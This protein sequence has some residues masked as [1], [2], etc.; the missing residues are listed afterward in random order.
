MG[1]VGRL[2]AQAVK[3]SFERAARQAPSDLAPALAAIRGVQQF[4]ADETDEIAGI[5]VLEENSLEI[6]FEEALAVY[7][8]MLADTRTAITCQPDESDDKTIGSGPFRLVS[9]DE[10]RVV[11]ERVETTGVGSGRRWTPSSSGP[12]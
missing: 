5:E 8:A 12:G 3:E 11:L 7:P 6:G 10:R 2:T 1:A 4:I 9:Q